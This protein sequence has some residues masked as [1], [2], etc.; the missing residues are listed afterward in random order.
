MYTGV[1]L[2]SAK[3]QVFEAVLG[4]LPDW[5]QITVLA[6]VVLAVVASWVVK[7]RRRLAR[8]RA[9]RTGLPLPGAAQP[10]RSG[11]DF[12]GPYAPAQRQGDR[13]A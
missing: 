8:R 4:F 10:G 6:L 7:V 3:T 13:P 12:L 2:A 11:A 9:S 1:P 5:V